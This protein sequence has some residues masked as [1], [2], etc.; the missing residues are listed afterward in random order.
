MLKLSVCVKAENKYKK[1]EI[2]KYVVSTNYCMLII[3][4]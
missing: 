2:L 3:Q 4:K 1:L